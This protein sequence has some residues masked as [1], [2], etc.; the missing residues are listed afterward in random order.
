[1]SL[2]GKVGLDEIN[3]Q[4]PMA[5]V[6]GQERPAFFVPQTAEK[7]GTALD[8]TMVQTRFDLQVDH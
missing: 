2:L 4:F 7:G 6:R 5:T 3:K 1:M 8:L